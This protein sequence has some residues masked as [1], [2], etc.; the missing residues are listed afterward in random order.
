MRRHSTHSVL[1]YV[2]KEPGCQPN[3]PSNCILTSLDIK[4]RRKWK[5]GIQNVTHGLRL[6]GITP[7]PK[8]H[9]I[10]ATHL[11]LL[12]QISVRITKKPNTHKEVQDAFLSLKDTLENSP[13]S[14]KFFNY[15]RKC[16]II[17]EHV[18]RANITQIILPRLGLTASHLKNYEI[19]HCLGGLRLGKN[20]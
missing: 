14:T 1:G 3:G 7:P 17:K 16:L 2:G 9:P 19:Q 20:G 6:L 8:T 18:W 5:K 10:S 12:P 15:D 4:K 11:T 13:R